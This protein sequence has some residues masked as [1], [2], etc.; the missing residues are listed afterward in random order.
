MLSLIV[1][2]ALTCPKTIVIN[3]AIIW[4]Q[5]DTQM[6]DTAKKRCGEIYPDAPCLKKFIKKDE[7]SYWAICGAQNGK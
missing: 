3:K 7:D 1:L 5:S 6:L 2:A 4:D